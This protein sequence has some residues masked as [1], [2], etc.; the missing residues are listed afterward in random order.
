M[1]SKFNPL[2]A[3]GSIANA[4]TDPMQQII[5][6]YDGAIKFLRLA[7]TD[8]EAGDLV[9]KAQH[10][11]RAL[12]I[13]SYLQSILDFERGGDVAPTLDFFYTTLTLQVLSASANLDGDQMRR[14]AE[15]LIPVREAWTAQVPALNSTF[16]TAGARPLA[17]SYQKIA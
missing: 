10:S 17:G 16:A 7:A 13:I 4:Q 5:L 6:L 2:A 1:S 12:A 15:L 8:I 9:A 14:A 3:Y 11:D